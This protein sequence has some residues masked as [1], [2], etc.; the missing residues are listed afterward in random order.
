MA[1]EGPRRRELAELHPDHV[2]VDRH[3]DEFAAV[4]D[5]EG[6]P[7]ELREDGGAARPGLDRGAATGLLRRLCLLE[8]RQL[9]ERTF[10][11]GAGHA[12]P[13]LLRVTRTDDHLVRRL[14]LAGAGTLGGLAPRG[15][16]VTAARGAA[17]AAAVR[18]VD[19]VFGDAAGQRA[20]AHPAAAAGLG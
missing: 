11:D 9:D 19:R 3:G 15:D 8:Q 6:Q 18:V 16:R 7:D 13:L 4:I 17:L 1:V 2:L 20:L 5:I 10:P 12:L 14:V